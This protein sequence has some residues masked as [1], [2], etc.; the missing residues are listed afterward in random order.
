M[1]RNSS[2]TTFPS[3]PPARHTPPE[4]KPRHGH[5][6]APMHGATRD[7][8]AGSHQHAGY[9]RPGRPPRAGTA[10]RSTIN[11]GARRSEDPT[12]RLAAGHADPVCALHALRISPVP[13]RSSIA[14]RKRCTAEGSLNE[15]GRL[16]L[17]TSQ[18]V[19]FAGKTEFTLP[20]RPIASSRP[21]LHPCRRPRGPRLGR[22]GVVGSGSN[23]CRGRLRSALQLDAFDRG[24][25]R[26]SCLGTLAR[27]AG[28]LSALL[29]LC[30]A[31]PG[32]RWPGWSHALPRRRRV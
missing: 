9:F 19:R 20:H 4:I 21:P 17:W 22:P 23:P 25:C 11:R 7:D 8:P 16:A 1:R 14:K 18:N 6:S 31:W 10:R 2:A 15:A 30:S 32:P 12:S 26:S 13:T 24:G 28:F 5:L 29:C 3:R 27:A